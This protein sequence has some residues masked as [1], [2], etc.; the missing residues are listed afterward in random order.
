LKTLSGSNINKIIQLIALLLLLLNIPSKIWGQTDPVFLNEDKEFVETHSYFDL[1]KTWVKATV[2]KKGNGGRI[3][4]SIAS[5]NYYQYEDNIVETQK[6][7]DKIEAFFLIPKTEANQE[8]KVYLYNNEL[9]EIYFKEFSVEFLK[10]YKYQNFEKLPVIDLIINDSNLILIDS[11]QQKA[12][13]I[14]IIPKS[15]KKWMNIAVKDSIG[16]YDAKVRIKGDW[17]DHIDNDK[18]SFRVK[19]KDSSRVFN[20]VKVFSIQHPKTRGYLREWLLHKVLEDEDVLTTKYDFVWLKQN[21]KSKG[22]YA[23]EQHFDK[24]LLERQNRREA[25]ILKFDEDGFWEIIKLK[26]K[27]GTLK[28]SYKQEYYALQTADILP[29][30]KN[31]TNKDL[32]LAIQF[33]KGADILDEFRNLNPVAL[34][35]FDLQKFAK[36]IALT[37]VLESYHSL[38]WI[39]L[40]FY[41][42][43]LSGLIEPVVYDGYESTKSEKFN[44][45][46][47]IG[48]VDQLH[49]TIYNLPQEIILQFFRNNDFR[50][51]YYNNLEKYSSIQFLDEV[52]KKY[53]NKIEKLTKD[54]KQEF[55][56]DIFNK[57]EYFIRANEIQDVLKQD[58]SNLLSESKKIE[59]YPLWKWIEDNPDIKP[60]FIDTS[61]FQSIALKAQYDEEQLKICNLHSQKIEVL[62]FYD[63]NDSVFYLEEPVTIK[64][65]NPLIP[66]DYV[67]FDRDGVEKIRYKLRGIEDVIKVNNKVK[68]VGSKRELKIEGNYKEYFREEEEALI[69]INNNLLIETRIVLPQK[70]LLKISKGTVIR[71]KD[72]GALIVQGDF[73]AEGTKEHPIIITGENNTNGIV[74]NGK[75]SIVELNYVF[76]E[77]LGQVSTNSISTTGGITF[78]NTICNIN[79]CIFENSRGEDMVN[80]INSNS[81]IINSN[82]KNAFSDALDIDYGKGS[83][84]DCNFYGALN[85]NIDISSATYSIEN[86]TSINAKDK[87]ISC[88]EKSRVTISKSQVENS[89]SGIVVKDQSEVKVL[90]TSIKNC[91]FGVKVFQKKPEYAGGKLTLTEVGFKDNINKQFKDNQSTIIKN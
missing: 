10:D 83:L 56:T 36:W 58:P 7:W 46:P 3:V 54:L 33:R 44:S 77:G 14:G 65:F 87:A 30:K 12:R 50:D 32:V 25:P 88:G 71:F 31:K 21:G 85:D 43:P 39:N 74:V 28:D 75:Y 16:I 86:T 42:N 11:A 45:T 78:Y 40:R 81:I 84:I 4:C 64:E 59:Y 24:Y 47:I 18:M 91:E 66:A 82:F 1:P 51:A 72:S 76:C 73:R 20:G 57:Q 53:G 68:I 63:K 61:L 35:Y 49:D 34:S 38:N 69:P 9:S 17:L 26:T 19:I 55:R 70:K 6:G 5:L 41:L 13:N 60:S 79:N 90:N 80:I 2:W 37:E 29:F 52:F 48:Y 23:F 15:G 22:I 62:A 8:L 27:S 89:T 67:V